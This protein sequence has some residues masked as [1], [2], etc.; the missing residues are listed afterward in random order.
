VDTT[1]YGGRKLEK[2]ADVMTNDPKEP[3]VHLTIVGPV[4]RF[5]TITPR[6]LSLRGVSGET[7]QG[8]VS[9]VPEEK[10]PFKVLETYA[11][12]GK[13]KVHLT[14]DVQEG[15]TVYVLRV[16]N[17]RTEAGAYQDTVRLKTDHPLQPEVDV[18]VYVYLRAPPSF[19][20]KAN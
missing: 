12:D 19:E 14:P 7:L 8:S 1:G 18:R 11:L 17:L 16:E 10:Y 5:A 9:I 4:D 3:V 2:S 6:M 13:L 20:K 15:R